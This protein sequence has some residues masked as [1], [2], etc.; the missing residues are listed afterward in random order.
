MVKLSVR[1]NLQ[2]KA[3]RGTEAVITAP[4]RKRMGASHVGSNPTI[5]AT[6]ENGRS[7]KH[8][9]RAIFRGLNTFRLGVKS[10]EEAVAADW[11]L[12]RIE[13]ACPA[14]MFVLERC[15]AFPV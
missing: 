10:L 9:R 6:F 12:D 2:L 5:S 8:G 7:E 4:P 1:M 11:C 13:C 3:W 14:V 15:N